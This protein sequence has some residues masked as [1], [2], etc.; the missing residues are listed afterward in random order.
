MTIN[1]L[2]ASGTSQRFTPSILAATAERHCGF[3]K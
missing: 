1:G 3:G 2:V